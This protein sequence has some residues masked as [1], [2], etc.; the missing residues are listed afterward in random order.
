MEVT[1]FDVDHPTGK[2][3][4]EGARRT[5]LAMVSIARGVHPLTRLPLHSDAAPAD[6]RQAPGARCAGCANKTKV[7]HNASTYLKCALV[8]ETR[9][10]STDLRAWWP[11]C[12][13][14]T[15]KE[16]L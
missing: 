8:T 7:G 9:G 3:L 6:D 15:P 5:A 14:Y 13:R 11:A 16:T 1:L 4:S 10:P 2:D 12:T